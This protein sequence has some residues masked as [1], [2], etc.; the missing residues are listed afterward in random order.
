VPTQCLVLEGGTANP[1]RVTHVHR[2]GS[3]HRPLRDPGSIALGYGPGCWARL[4]T[5]A[6]AIA[7]ADRDGADESLHETTLAP[8]A[9]ATPITAATPVSAATTSHVPRR[10]TSPLAVVASWTIVLLAVY[11]LLEHW[12]WVLGGVA[13]V[14][15]TAA[16]GLLVEGVQRRR[17]EGHGPSG[18]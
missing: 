1:W 18:P 5:T 15:A 3:C 11:V 6:R 14:A 8:T 16:V 12:R 13:L 7:L 4:G 2:C 10:S 17:A 9:A